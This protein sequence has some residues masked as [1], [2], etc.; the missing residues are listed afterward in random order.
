MLSTHAQADRDTMLRQIEALKT[1][2]QE[3]GFL[4][5]QWGWTSCRTRTHMHSRCLRL[6]VS[7]SPLTRT[8]APS[9]SFSHKQAEGA[10][11]EV[12]RL[13]DELSNTYRELADVRRH[14][15]DALARL[16]EQSEGMLYALDGRGPGGATETAV[17][18]MRAV[19]EATINELKDRLG[20]R[21]RQ[22]G[23]MQVRSASAFTS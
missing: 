8:H 2:R 11:Q 1:A 21:D 22:I 17:S 12:G 5:W 4:W 18:Q 19:A 7:L 14:H 13:S 10:K 16:K 15:N 6:S 20:G 3:V 9:L 23:E